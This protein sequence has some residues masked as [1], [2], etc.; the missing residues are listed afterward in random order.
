MRNFLI[1]FLR[2]LL[3]IAEGPQIMVSEVDKQDIKKELNQKEKQP[4]KK[5]RNKTNISVAVFKE[6]PA[7]DLMNLME[8]P[9]VALSKKRVNP[10]IYESSDGTR[11]ITI[12]GHRGHFLASIY[13]WDII[14]FVAGKIQEILNNGS[15]IPPRALTIPRYEILK[16]LHK[17]NVNTQ[18]RE[19]EKSLSRLQL[20]G[21]DTTIHNKD[22]RYR[23]GFGFIDSW[24]YT[25]RKDIKEIRITLSQWLYD[26]CCAK[27]ALLRVNPTYFDLTSGLKKFLYRTGRK[28]VGNNEDVWEFSIENLY[29]KSGS[30]SEFKIF[31]NKL[32][33]AVMD[34]DI[35]EYFMQWAKKNKKD[36]VL[37]KRLS[38]L[39]KIERTAEEINQ[40]TE[41][42]DHENQVK[43]LETIGGISR[44]WI[45]MCTKFIRSKD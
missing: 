37:F 27:G 14:L 15:D 25:E 40:N 19:L 22:F 20:T 41:K 33:K 24:D 12:S 32:K 16:A 17:H 5:K 34:N 7:R 45:T 36:F 38:T 43:G 29:E 18:Q 9:F 26:I 3:K 4:E 30:E 6:N 13:D 21:I 44:T 28:H 11:K 35:P 1:P 8:F 2:K 42:K 23:A 39:E 10:I 31:K